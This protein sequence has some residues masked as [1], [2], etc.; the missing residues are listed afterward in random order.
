[1]CVFPDQQAKFGVNFN[2]PVNNIQNF[3]VSIFGHLV[4]HNVCTRW[5]QRRASLSLLSVSVRVRHTGHSCSDTHTFLSVGMWWP[6]NDSSLRLGSLAEG[7]A[8]YRQHADYTQTRISLVTTH[9]RSSWSRSLMLSVKQVLLANF[10]P[11]DAFGT[12]LFLLPVPTVLSG[13]FEK[14]RIVTI[15]FVMSVCPRGKT[16]LPPDGYHGILYFN[17]F[18]KPV[19]D[20]QVTLTF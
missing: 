9:C 12:F 15:K 11:N 14:L 20:I 6:P 10:L 7:V 17:V 2:D 8:A 19:E 3:L 4:I 13:A 16:R 5:F 18:R 1:M